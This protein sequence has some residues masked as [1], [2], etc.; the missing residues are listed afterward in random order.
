MSRQLVLIAA[1][2]VLL[3]VEFTPGC[4]GKTVRKT[5]EDDVDLELRKMVEETREADERKDAEELWALATRVGHLVKG[6]QEVNNL[7]KTKL[8]SLF[9]TCFACHSS[10]TNKGPLKRCGH[11]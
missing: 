5:T 3:V 1:F 8:S 11:S 7:I 9:M 2:L 6:H 10:R 4:H